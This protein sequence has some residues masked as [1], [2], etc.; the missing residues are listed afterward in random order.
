LC[1]PENLVVRAD[2]S[3]LAPSL[4][5][6]DNVNP[7]KEL[8]GSL[9]LVA[10]GHSKAATSPPAAKAAVFRTNRRGNRVAASVESDKSDRMN[11]CDKPPIDSCASTS[12]PKSL[13][14]SSVQ[15]CAVNLRR[16]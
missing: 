5:D 16:D 6:I 1:D 7:S 3:Q 11:Y 14:R 2:G 4:V 8:T 12:P 10:R 9:P 13:I 15:P